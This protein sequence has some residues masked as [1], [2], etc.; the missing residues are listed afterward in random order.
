[1][2]LGER[3][4]EMRWMRGER[5]RLKFLQAAW[6]DIVESAARESVDELEVTRGRA[7][8]SDGV[9]GV[10]GVVSGGV[11]V[12]VMSSCVCGVACGVAGGPERALRVG[13]RGGNR[14]EQVKRW[15]LRVRM[16]LHG[17]PQG[18]NVMVGKSCWSA[19]R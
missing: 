13:K 12:G 10:A 14:V 7:G 11:V 3:V 8:R 19:G 18:Q 17:C 6:R 4:E 15:V 16:L 5:R 2:E 1:M 9:T